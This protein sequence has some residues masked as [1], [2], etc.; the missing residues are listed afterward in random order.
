VPV[1]TD[2]RISGTGWL[3]AAVDIG[4]EPGAVAVSR[5]GFCF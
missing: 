3:A 2:S 1:Y 4:S 5:Q